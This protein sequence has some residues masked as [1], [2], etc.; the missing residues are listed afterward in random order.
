MACCSLGW[1][2]AVLIAACTLTVHGAKYQY[3]EQSLPRD[4]VLLVLEF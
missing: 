4:S 3:L 1:V 2:A